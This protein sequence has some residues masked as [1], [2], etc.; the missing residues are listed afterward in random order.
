MKRLTIALGTTSAE[1]R[2]VYMRGN[3]ERSWE[4]GSME[5]DDIKPLFVKVVKQIKEIP[6]TGLVAEIIVNPGA[7]SPEEAF[8]LRGVVH[9]EFPHEIDAVPGLRALAATL[10]TA[11]HGHCNT[12]GSVR[13]CVWC[14]GKSIGTLV[15][16]G[17]FHLFPLRG[18]VSDC[19]SY[20]LGASDGGEG[21]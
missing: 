11:F 21:C 3:V 12:F 6:A 19:I 4:L 15:A 14:G 20:A 9:G 5:A 16:G 18:C 13:T 2:L 1:A 8:D 10:L 7:V 17:G